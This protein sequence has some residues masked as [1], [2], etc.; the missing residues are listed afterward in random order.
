[1]A[2]TIIVSVLAVLSLTGWMLT[3]LL[4]SIVNVNNANALNLVVKVNRYVDD[5]LNAAVS[6]L[7]Q[8]VATRQGGGT[9]EERVQHAK[10][11]LDDATEKMREA[12]RDATQFGLN[13]VQEGAEGP[14]D[15]NL[16]GEMPVEEA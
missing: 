9:P 13:R 2:L 12:M 15:S 5:N 14:P 1:M 10:T 6:R 7:R 4:H 16:G 3:N 8:A 11:V